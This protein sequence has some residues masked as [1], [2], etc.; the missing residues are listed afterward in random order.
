MSYRRAIGYC[1]NTDCEDYSKG[2]FLINHGTT[3]YCPK[4]RDTGKVVAEQ[5]FIDGRQES[6]FKEV[7]VEFNFDPIS[8][9]FREIGIVR[10]DNVP[11]TGRTYTLLTPLIKTENRALKVAE[12]ILSNLQCN[13]EVEDGELPRTTEIIVSFDDELD[14]F[15]SK[16][17]KLGE[18]WEN[19]D[20]SEKKRKELQPIFAED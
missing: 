1:E 14:V 2:V 5:G 16:M 10:D 20:L 7:R 12:A 3:F 17:K 13:V 18:A 8:H 15:F 4:C 11:D 9:R 6:P 19:S